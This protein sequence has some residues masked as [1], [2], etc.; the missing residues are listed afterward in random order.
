MRAER[1]AG[2]LI[3]ADYLHRNA[4]GCGFIE[5]GVRGDSVRTVFQKFSVG[6][7]RHLWQRHGLRCAGETE[8][9]K[10]DGHRQGSK[11]GDLEDSLNHLE[12]KQ[13]RFLQQ[14]A[15]SFCHVCSFL[16][17]GRREFYGAQVI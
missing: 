10:S 6:H 15:N 7:A 5:H 13:D 14:S 4:H 1:V 2:M 3:R 8:N 11:Q 9:D 12:W 17:V 16:L